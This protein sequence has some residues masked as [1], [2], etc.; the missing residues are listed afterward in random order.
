MNRRLIHPA[1]AVLII[2]SL[3]GCGPNKPAAVSEAPKAPVADALVIQPPAGGLGED[4][5]R[6]LWMDVLPLDKGDT[7][8]H[9]YVEQDLVFAVTPNNVVYTLG[10]PTGVLEYFRYVNGGG[11]QIGTPVVLPRHIVYVGQ[12]NLEIYKRAGGEYEKTIPLD[13]TIS[14]DAVGEE[15]DLYLGADLGG[16]QLADIDISRDYHNIVWRVLMFGAVVGA[17][18]YYD[19]VIFVGSGDGGVRAVNPDRTGLWPLDGDRYD[20]GGEILGDVKADDDGVYAASHSGRLVC[21]NRNNGKLKW[22]YLAPQPLGAGPVVTRTSVYQYVPDVGLVAIDKSKLIPVDTAGERK[23]EEVNRTPRWIC[24]QAVQFVSEDRLFTYV[25][26]AD[27]QLWAVDRDSGQVRYRGQAHF[28]ALATN[29]VDST[30]YAVNDD[31][32]VYAI[33]PEL[34]PGNPGYLE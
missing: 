22:Q 20:T 34:Q 21:L 4:N 12:S 29:T 1:G 6:Q 9:L 15:N 26:T 19:N 18:A 13:F 27:N 8:N 30:I 32:A 10:K 7:V 33:K 2:L 11:R 14:S 17:P 31:G 16:G 25:R 23:V 28:T 3:A 24:P 5:F